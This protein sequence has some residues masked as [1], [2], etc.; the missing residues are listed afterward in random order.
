MSLRMLPQGKRSVL[1]SVGSPDT[2]SL[3]L[4]LSLSLSSCDS[5][6]TMESCLDFN[7]SK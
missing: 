1:S 2:T 6:L 4:S 7:L 3:S 5:R